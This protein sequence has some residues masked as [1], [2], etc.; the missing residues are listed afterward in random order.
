MKVSTLIEKLQQFDGDDDVIA[1]VVSPDG[2]TA[3][4]GDI[5]EVESVAY[6]APESS[7]QID[8]RPLED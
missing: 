6:N 3:E 4:D 7:V 8:V 1:T 5:M 2:I